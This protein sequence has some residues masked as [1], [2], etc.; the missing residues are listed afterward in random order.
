[1]VS[2]ADL[3]RLLA[4]PTTKLLVLPYGSAFPEADADA[5]TQYLQRGGNLLTLGGRPF[6]RPID[7]DN[8]PRPETYAYP[9]QLLLSDYQSTGPSTDL[10]PLTNHDLLSADLPPI[11]YTDAF[12]VVIRL[13]DEGSSTRIGASGL[14]DST[15]TTLLWGT[16]L[17]QKITAPVIQIDHFRNNF[18]G[19]RWIMLNATPTQPPPANLITRLAA[20]ALLGPSDFTA[21]PS[22]PLYLPTETPTFDVTWLHSTPHA[23]PNHRHPHHHHQRPAR[24]HPD[25]PLH[26]I[27]TPHHPL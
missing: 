19:G 1:M 27:H 15:L 16:R 25:H 3:P 13:S 22:E 18:A 2:A 11:T 5:I 9:R 20:Q 14:P 6:T 21:I 7:R 10:T 8:H 17:D 12:S 23:H 24:H 4:D 26:L